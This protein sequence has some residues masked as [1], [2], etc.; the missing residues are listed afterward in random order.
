M[1]RLNNM[2]ITFQYECPECEESIEAKYTPERP[3]PF[4]MDH[5]SPKF[6]DPGDSSEVEC[7]ESKCPNCG[8]IITDDELEEQ[9]AK[10]CESQRDSAD[11]DRAEREY[12]M[13]EERMDRMEKEE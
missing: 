7:N 2:A 9:G 10:A 8:H 12:E 5:D 11:E 1:E 3:A 6:S 4:C 13:R